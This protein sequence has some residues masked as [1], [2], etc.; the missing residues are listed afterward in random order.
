MTFKFGSCFDRQENLVSRNP[1]SALAKRKKNIPTVSRDRRSKKFNSKLVRIDESVDDLDSCSGNEGRSSHVSDA[2]NSFGAGY[3]SGVVGD[4][5]HE[6][7]R[8]YISGSLFNDKD[9]AGLKKN[10]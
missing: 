7:S 4:D 8:S 2:K 6:K 10:T 3:H 9:S 5:E 1:K